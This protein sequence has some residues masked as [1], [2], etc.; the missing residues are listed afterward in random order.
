MRETKGDQRFMSQPN[1]ETNG[2]TF[3]HVK[4]EWT[5]GNLVDTVASLLTTGTIIGALWLGLSGVIA[6]ANQV[7]DIK[8]RQT[9][10]QSEVNVLK[11]QRKSDKDE[12]QGLQKSLDALNR[13]IDHQ[14]DL[15]LQIVQQ[16]NHR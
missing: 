7:P 13:K 3:P 8:D 5:I 11:S 15:L 1:A 10:L 12:M 14:N 2:Q 4:R 6:N 16:G 9:Q